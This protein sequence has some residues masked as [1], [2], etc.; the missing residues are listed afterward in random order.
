MYVCIGSLKS[1]ME[2]LLFC[3]GLVFGSFSNVLIDRT[4]S[5]ESVLWGRSHCDFCKKTLRWHELIPVLSFLLQWGKCRRCHKHLSVQYPV[6]ELVTALGY[7]GISQYI[8]F[9]IVYILSA[10]IFSSSL[11]LFMADYKYQ[12]LPDEMVLLG[13]LAAFFL[14]II[15]YPT[16]NWLSYFASSVG[17]MGFFYILWFGTKGKGMG[18][19]DVKLAG[20]MGLVLGFPSIVF[21]LYIAFL[22]GATVGVI[23][24]LAKNKSLKSKIAFG[25]FMIF[26]LLIA[27]ICNRQ[28]LAI[29]HSYF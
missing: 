22:T 10:I 20:M 21:S 25:P 13:S 23:L 12:I 8:P 26:G 9:G 17:A 5:G 3:Y 15:S 27:I 1:M 29:W 19:G 7:L 2:F 6:I 24:I 14:M 4:E 11:V 28:L 18:F 16:A